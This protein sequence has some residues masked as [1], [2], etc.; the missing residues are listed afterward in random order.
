MHGNNNLSTV[1]VC[2]LRLHL[3]AH[4]LAAPGVDTWHELPQACIKN[5]N[6]ENSVFLGP[7]DGTIHGDGYIYCTQA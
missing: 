3:L 6:G 1:R 5:L 7:D 2:L 4:L